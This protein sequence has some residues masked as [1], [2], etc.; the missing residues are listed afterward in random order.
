VPASLLISTGA[1]PQNYGF[2]LWPRIDL[3]QNDQIS[4]FAPDN[5]L[6][7]VGVPETRDRDLELL[8]VGAIGLVMRHR[9]QRAGERPAA[10]SRKPKLL[11]TYNHRGW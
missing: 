8:G 9:R 4:D 6:L 3:G 10:Q 5:A 11:G 1:V 2:N 7:R